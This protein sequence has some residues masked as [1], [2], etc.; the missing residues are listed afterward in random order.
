MKFHVFHMKEQY[1]NVINA[2]MNLKVIYMIY[3]GGRGVNFVM[4]LKI[5]L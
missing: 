1:L 2:H 5:G 4:Q 3:Q